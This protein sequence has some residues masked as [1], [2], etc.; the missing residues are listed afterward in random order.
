MYVLGYVALFER[1]GGVSI[2][3]RILGLHG[4]KF[5]VVGEGL[6]VL[7]RAATRL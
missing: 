4:G 6:A 2:V 3:E 7:P 5:C 1:K